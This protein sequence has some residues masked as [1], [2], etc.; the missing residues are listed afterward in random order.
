MGIYDR[1]Y[2]R[3]EGPSFLA[4]FSDRGKI[5]KWLILANVICFVAQF[6]TPALGESDYGWFT[7]FFI[8]NVDEVIHHGQ[9]WRLLTYAFLHDTSSL[10][11]ILFNMLFLWWFGSDVEDLYGPREF[12]AVY[13]V[14][15]V[16]GGAAFVLASLAGLGGELCLGA[17][18]A[19]T[20]V[21][22]LCAVHYPRRII[23]LFFLLPIPIW[24]LVVFN[25][26][27]DLVGF[28]GFGGSNTAFS[29]H[30]A[31]AAFAFVYYKMNWR[32]LS[33][34]PSP[35]A[36]RRRR[37]RARL[38]IYQEE[39]EEPRTPLRVGA[40]AD[41]E[42]DEQLEARMD[43]VLQKVQDHGLESLS[44]NERNILLKA[45]EAIKRKRR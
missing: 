36:W 29:V 12:L 31:G 43:A 41:R 7:N 2:Y 13:L 16:L 39:E 19:V 11:H 21:M 28:L 37:S 34:L 14:S 10:W 20:A 18:G 40:P 4:S 42:V 30:L 25:V 24:L 5:C 38:R 33:V 15:A 32:L 9:V 1:D 27:R 22:V 44:E 6:L 3:R 35:G 8:L 23:Y 45:S 17:S 26:A